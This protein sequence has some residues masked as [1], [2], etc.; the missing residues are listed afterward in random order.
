MDLAGSSLTIRFLGLCQK[1][2]P[3]VRWEA[4]KASKHGLVSPVSD[5]NMTFR[6]ARS[7]LLRNG[8]RCTSDS[9]WVLWE[10]QQSLSSSAALSTIDRHLGTMQELIQLAS[11]PSA[12][13]GQADFALVQH[14][15]VADRDPHY[16]MPH[17]ALRSTYS[18]IP[19]KVCPHSF[20]WPS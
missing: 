15:H 8:D 20:L 17:V 6:T 10:A 3:V 14:A 11:S 1:L 19:I 18:L 9:Q 2:S 12:L 13:M 5:P 16:G 4:T 7:A